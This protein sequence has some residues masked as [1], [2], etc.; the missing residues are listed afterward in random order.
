MTKSE[1]SKRMGILKLSAK[2]QLHITMGL[3]YIYSTKLERIFATD[4]AF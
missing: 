3:A 4:D 1:M 2:L